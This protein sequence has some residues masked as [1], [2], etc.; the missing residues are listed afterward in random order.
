MDD[1]N[2]FI[3]KSIK[4]TEKIQEAIRVVRENIESAR[5]RVFRVRDILHRGLDEY[6]LNKVKDNTRIEAIHI[7]ERN[8]LDALDETEEFNLPFFVATLIEAIYKKETYDIQI[9][10]SGE[11]NVFVEIDLDKTAGTL[12]EYAAGIERGRSE[13]SLTMSPEAASAFWAVFLYGTAREGRTVSRLYGGSSPRA[14]RVDRTAYHQGLYWKTLAARIAGFGGALAPWWR[15]LEFGTGISIPSDR[16]GEPYPSYSGTHFVSKSE[17]EINDYAK[18]LLLE[19]ENEFYNDWQRIIRQAE[20]E[21]DALN[22]ELEELLKTDLNKVDTATTI[23]NE[24]LR[25]FYTEHRLETIT[26]EMVERISERIVVGQVKRVVLGSGIRIRTIN[27][28]KEYNKRLEDM[29]K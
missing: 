13:H 11:K 16:G 1:L 6:L 9:S 21:L 25:N 17:L 18:R 15:I 12:K 28:F 10:S 2:K 29:L 14:R 24:H 19:T 5:N 22:K 8:A 7:L 26:E 23:I 4:N 27:I 3:D 20:S